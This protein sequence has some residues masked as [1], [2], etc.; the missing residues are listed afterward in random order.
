MKNKIN[1]CR[2]KKGELDNNS[3]DNREFSLEK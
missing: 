1:P 3:Y 2:L